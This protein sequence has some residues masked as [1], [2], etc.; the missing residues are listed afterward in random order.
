MCLTVSQER[1]LCISDCK[2]DS[3]THSKLEI[4]VINWNINS[5]SK[6]EYQYSLATSKSLG[7]FQ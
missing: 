1:A 3:W 4:T 6:L 2:F 5:V 7:L